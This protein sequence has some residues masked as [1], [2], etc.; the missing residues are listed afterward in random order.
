[1]ARRD[2]QKSAGFDRHARLPVEEHRRPAHDYIGLIARVRCLSVFAVRAIELD[3][4]CAVREHGHRE[5]T[6]RR[7]RER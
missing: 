3:F 6:G 2:E 7:G 1:L 4:E 5:V